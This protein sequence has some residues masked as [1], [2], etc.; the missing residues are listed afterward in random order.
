ML[1]K[2]MVAV[3]AVVTE[4]LIQEIV[5][6]LT[7]QIT[8]ARAELE[9]LD[10]DVTHRIYQAQSGPSP[11]HIQ[12]ALQMRQQWHQEKLRREQAIAAAEQR[13]EEARGLVLGTLV[14]RGQVEGWVE[15][16]EGTHLKVALEGGKLI[17]RD[18]IVL[19]VRGA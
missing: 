4:T 2:R 11:Q 5:N 8:H 1:I 19:E 15:V 7:A 3:Q 10:K 13:C 18:D 17:V 6:D 9:Q 12:A 16:S 14:H